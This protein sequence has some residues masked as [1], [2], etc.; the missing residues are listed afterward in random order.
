MNG[1]DEINSAHDISI[2]I[3]NTVKENDLGELDFNSKRNTPEKV[4]EEPELKD[5]GCQTDKIN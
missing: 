3:S 1:D 5:R 4:K 2:S